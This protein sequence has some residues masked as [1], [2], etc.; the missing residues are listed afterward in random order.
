MTVISIGDH[1]KPV[2]KVLT[3]PLT[4]KPAWLPGDSAGNLTPQM[5]LS[6]L[7]DFG[8]ADSSYG[9]CLC[10]LFNLSFLV[11]LDRNLFY[12]TNFIR[13]Y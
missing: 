5:P 3:L 4:L 2:R 8:R 6:L 7:K 10:M 1:K 12:L 11:P 9:V 13:F